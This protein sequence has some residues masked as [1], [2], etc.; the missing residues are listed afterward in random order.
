MASAMQYREYA[1]ECLTWAKEA[2]SDEDREAL[3]QL[4]QDWLQAAIKA[5]PLPKSLTAC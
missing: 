2:Q 3:I 1:E 4:A 5:E